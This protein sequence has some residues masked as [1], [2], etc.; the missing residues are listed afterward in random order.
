MTTPS[1]NLTMMDSEAYCP[2][3]GNSKPTSESYCQDCLNEGEDI[4]LDVDGWEAEA[5]YPYDYLPEYTVG[6][7]ADVTT[8]TP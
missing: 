3:C 1:E 7:V 4:T 5:M 6:Y 2:C 8:F